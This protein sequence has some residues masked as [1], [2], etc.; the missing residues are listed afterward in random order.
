MTP[1]SA[2]LELLLTRPRD[3]S[4]GVPAGLV[5]GLELLVGRVN[6]YLR[7]ATTL[8]EMA[9]VGSGKLNLQTAEIDLSAVIRQA[10]TNMLPLAESAGCEGRISVEDRV[11]AL[12]DPD[13]GRADL[14]ESAC[15]HG[16]TV[17][18]M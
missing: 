12:C 9:R 15:R 6:A 3:M 14:G 18:F 10:T 1:I 8:L 2:R 17:R 13:G 7:R 16:V 11:S 5:H 4:G